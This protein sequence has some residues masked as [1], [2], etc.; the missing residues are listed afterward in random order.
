MAVTGFLKEDGTADKQVKRRNKFLKPGGS[1][2]K[3]KVIQ[4]VEEGDAEENASSG[5]SCPSLSLSLRQFWQSQEEK[6]HKSPDRR[7]AE[8]WKKVWEDELRVNGRK[9]KKRKKE[10]R[11]GEGGSLKS[12]SIFSCVRG[13]HTIVK[14]RAMRSGSQIK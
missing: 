11:D 2:G 4:R 7:H 12:R 5:S 8:V 14:K 10:P 13:G 3:G 9:K 6:G 1:E